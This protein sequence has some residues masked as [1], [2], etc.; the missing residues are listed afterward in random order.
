MKIIVSAKMGE[1]KAAA[2]CVIHEA[3]RA[4]GFEVTKLEDLDFPLSSQ[5]EID[6]QIRNLANRKDPP[7]IKVEIETRLLHRTA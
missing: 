5:R 1:R 2:A 3:L 4:A 6:N 7:K